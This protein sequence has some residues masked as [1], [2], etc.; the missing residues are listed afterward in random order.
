[1]KGVD[2][3]IPSQEEKVMNIAAQLTFSFLLSLE[4]FSYSTVSPQSVLGS[5]KDITN[6]FVL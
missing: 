3:I 5:L 4:L 6:N 1:M 2:H